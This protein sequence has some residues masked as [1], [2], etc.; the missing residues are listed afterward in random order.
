MNLR[1]RPESPA[2]FPQ[3]SDL[4]IAAFGQPDEAR[5]I[6]LIRQSPH[7]VPELALV[8]EEEGQIVGQLMLSRIGL[9]SNPPSQ[10]LDLAPMAVTPARQRS[11]VGSALVTH[12]LGEADRRREPLVVVLG[13]PGYY[14]KFG[15]EPASRHGIYPPWPNIPDAAFMVALLSGYKQHYR[16]T[17]IYPPAFDIGS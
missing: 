14:P 11:G 6:E 15:F 2:D 8:A 12:A 5:L 7:Y 9:A 4:V 1:I 13:H 3:I 16:G 17:V 10:V